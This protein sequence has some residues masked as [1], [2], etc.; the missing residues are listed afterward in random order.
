[1]IT[2]K[3]S[4]TKWTIS[5][6]RRRANS[7]QNSSWHRLFSVLLGLFFNPSILHSLLSG[8]HCLHDKFTPRKQAI[9]VEFQVSTKRWGDFLSWHQILPS[10]LKTH[11]KSELGTWSAPAINS[12]GKLCGFHFCFCVC[13]SVC[14][15]VCVCARTHIPSCPLFLPLKWSEMKSLSRVW[16]FA[17][18][19]TVAYQAPPSMGFSRKEYLSGVPC[20]SPEDLPDP[21]I[22]PGFPAL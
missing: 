21:G 4:I 9:K 14:V 2:L 16:L 10:L 13:V 17:T 8:W 1:M 5:Q 6:T 11:C 15:C 18:P 3:S 22:E 19:W 20:P 12:P 7:R